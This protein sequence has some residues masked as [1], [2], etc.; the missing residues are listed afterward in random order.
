MRKRAVHVLVDQIVLRVE[1]RVIAAEQKIRKL[2]IC[3]AEQIKAS[4]VN[5]QLGS[6]GDRRCHMYRQCT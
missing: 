3:Q 6:S 2:R 1:Q 5:I 4:I